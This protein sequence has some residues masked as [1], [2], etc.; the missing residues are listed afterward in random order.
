MYASVMPRSQQLA[1]DSLRAVVNQ[2]SELISS[3]TR[4]NV[5]PRHF[6]VFYEGIEAGWAAKTV[7]CAGKHFNGAEV[8]P[9]VLNS[10]K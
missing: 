7:L 2:A 6:W 5:N 3:Y 9:F 8:A 10:N 1:Q 4:Q